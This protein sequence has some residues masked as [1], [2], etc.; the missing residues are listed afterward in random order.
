[1][2]AP[3]SIRKIGVGRYENHQRVKRVFPQHFYQIQ[4]VHSRH[5]DIHQEYLNLI[6]ITAVQRFFGVCESSANLPVSVEM[7]NHLS[8]PIQNYL[9]VIN[10]NNVHGISSFVR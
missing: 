7:R 6:P 4:S 9:F 10:E 2:C 8:Q 5:T 1:M 3:L